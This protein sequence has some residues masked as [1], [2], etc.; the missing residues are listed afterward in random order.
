MWYSLVEADGHNPKGVDNI[1]EQL[2]PEQ[3]SEA[4]HLYE[5]WKPGRCEREIMGT[6]PINT[7]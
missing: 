3:L 6:E 1:R 4:D 2:T 7:Q 5:N